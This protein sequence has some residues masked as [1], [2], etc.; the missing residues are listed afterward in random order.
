MDF[1]KVYDCVT[2][3]YA[4]FTGRAARSEYWTFVLAN[5]I[6]NI[7]ISILGKILD[8]SFLMTLYSLA[9]LVPSLAVGVRRLHDLDKSGW[10]SLLCLVPFVGPIVLIVWTVMKGTEGENRFGSDPL[11][12]AN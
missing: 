5:I 3:N 11:Q 8:F 1:E 2:V 10:W 9:V 6:G 4:K 12:L 7:L